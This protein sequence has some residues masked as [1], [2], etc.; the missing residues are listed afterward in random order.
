[1][2]AFKS[3]LVL[4]PW[5][6][7]LYPP[8]FSHTNTLLT[9]T[10]DIIH[11]GRYSFT[12]PVGNTLPRSPAALCWWWNEEECAP[13]FVCF[14]FCMKEEEVDMEYVTSLCVYMH[15]CCQDNTNISEDNEDSEW[16]KTFSWQKQNDFF[17]CFSIFSSWLFPFFCVFFPYSFAKSPRKK[18]PI[19]VQ[20]ASAAFQM[21]NCFPLWALLFPGM[22]ISCDDQRDTGIKVLRFKHFVVFILLP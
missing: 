8:S 21:H 10:V 17:L 3:P 16:D 22:L 19:F 6:P 1:M 2:L 4:W 11:A 12:L 20:A 9:H 15:V 13:M 14:L 7:A 18:T 5:C